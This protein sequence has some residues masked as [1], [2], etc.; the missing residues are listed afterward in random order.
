MGA[1]DPIGLP[2]NAERPAQI[3]ALAALSDPDFVTRSVA[4][5]RRWLPRHAETARA[6]GLQPVPSATNFTTIRFPDAPAAEAGLARAGLIVRGLKGYGLPDH[7][8]ITVGTDAENEA[9][10]AALEGLFSRP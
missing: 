6:L 4:H 9:L 10:L 1:M 2:F 8:R 7:L 5:V 3:E